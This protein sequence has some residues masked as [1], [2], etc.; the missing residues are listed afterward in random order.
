MMWGITQ[1]E[2]VLPSMFPANSQN[3]WK[4]HISTSILHEA[5]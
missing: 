2:R 4:S 1:A 3:E 5:F